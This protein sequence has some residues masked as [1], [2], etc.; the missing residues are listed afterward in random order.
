MIKHID[1]DQVYIQ[2]NNN[3]ERNTNLQNQVKLKFLCEMLA[4]DYFLFSLFKFQSTEHATFPKLSKS[5]GIDRFIQISRFAMFFSQCCLQPP[6][7]NKNIS[8]LF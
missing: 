4:K 5:S 2:I 3:L 1:I 7:K 8:F 6:S